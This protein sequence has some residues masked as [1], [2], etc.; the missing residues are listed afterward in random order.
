M[1]KV[2]QAILHALTEIV[3]NEPAIAANV[4]KLLNDLVG[5]AVP[6]TIL[7]APAPAAAAPTPAAA[8]AAVTRTARLHRPGQGPRP[9]CIMTRTQRILLLAVLPGGLVLLAAWLWWS[10]RSRTS[11]SSPA[12]TNTDTHLPTGSPGPYSPA[13]SAGNDQASP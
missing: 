13:G 1:N 9:R 5:P 2:T 12:P 8:P 3:T 10:K 4:R 11:T 6:V 7:P